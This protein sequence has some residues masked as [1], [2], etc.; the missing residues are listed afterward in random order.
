MTRQEPRRIANLVALTISVIA[1][2]VS[3]ANLYMASLRAPH[4]EVRVAPYI[5]HGIDDTSGNEAFFIPL[6]MANSGAR[7]TSI[8]SLE[9]YI[10]HV[11]TGDEKTLYGQYFAEN[12]AILG[13]FFTPI[14]LPGYSDVSRTVAFYPL[15]ARTDRLFE[16][17][18]VYVFQLTALVT[19]V[20]GPSGTEV[21]Q[22][23]EFSINLSAQQSAAIQEDPEFEYQ[24]PLA[25]ER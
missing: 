21:L 4:V 24:F 2:S 11:P 5:R 19:D 20:G 17:P 9:L 10:R 15:G 13:E 8:L 12:L 23:E 7:P 25:I 6:T 22:L 14:A 3:I 18:G 1:L 16:S